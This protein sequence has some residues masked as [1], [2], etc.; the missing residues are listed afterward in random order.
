MGAKPRND[1][2]IRVI[3]FICVIVAFS[4]S[5]ILHAQENNR[6]RDSV[7]NLLKLSS[8]DR[9]ILSQKTGFGSRVIPSCFSTDFTTCRQITTSPCYSSKIYRYCDYADKSVVVCDAFGNN[10]MGFA[11]YGNDERNKY[12]IYYPDDVNENSP[13]VVLIHGGGWFKGPSTE[14]LR[15]YPFKFALDN[16]DS[17]YVA[18]LL[19]NGYVVVSM[20]YRLGQLGNTESEWTSNQ[21]GWQEQIDD[22]DAA[23]THIRTN[24]P[25]C[26]SLNANSIQVVG[27]SAGGHLALMWAYTKSDLSYVKSVV[28]MYAPTNVN[29][30][31]DYLKNIYVGTN[32]QTHTCGGMYQF[33]SVLCSLSASGSFFPRYFA[34]DSTSVY[35]FNNVHPF[36]CH[37]PFIRTCVLNGITDDYNTY[38]SWKIFYSYNMIQTQ[39]K[40]AIS[41]P[42]TNTHLQLYSPSNALNS[43][44]IAPTFIMHGEADLLVP[45]LNSTNNMNTRLNN[46][47]GLISTLVNLNDPVP[48]SYQ[49]NPNKHL[50]KTYDNANHGWVVT[51]SGS[52]NLQYTDVVF[53]K[54]RH[55]SIAWLNGHK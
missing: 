48:S 52:N 11:K 50:I 34:Y 36:N 14:T 43:S 10:I 45:Y 20:L 53:Y 35:E 12:Y 31:A 33:V 39:S 26:L 7:F 1:R 3:L 32:W 30:Y 54:V 37:S 55:E 27:E 40:Q 21:N 29:Q 4:T 41:N 2:R 13:I 46:Y 24:F 28:S 44:R 19:D 15:G 22:I 49:T 47:G 23:I 16:V 42:L 9:D 8:I 51:N 18:D 38:K 6:A 25:T 5:S 17:S